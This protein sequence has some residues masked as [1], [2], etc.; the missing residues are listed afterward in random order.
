MANHPE[1][2]G[3]RPHS[4]RVT[5]ISA[6]TMEVAKGNANFPKLQP[7]EITARPI[8]RI[9]RKSTRETARR[10]SFPR[11]NSRNRL[12]GA[13]GPRGVEKDKPVFLEIEDDLEEDICASQRNGQLA[14]DSAIAHLDFLGPIDLPGMGKEALRVP[15]IGEIV[16]SEPPGPISPEKKRIDY[17]LGLVSHGDIGNMTYRPQLSISKIIRLFPSVYPGVFGG[18]VAVQIAI[19]V[20]GNLPIRGVEIF[21]IQWNV[22]YH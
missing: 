17:E 13:K 9:R 18:N 4:L 19:E 8:P 21:W 10:N 3:I 14:A 1:G 15:L 12:S 5:E 16:I 6:L 11:R 22:S 2:H 20:L 7:R